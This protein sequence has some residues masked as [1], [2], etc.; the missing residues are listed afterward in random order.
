MISNLASLLKKLHPATRWLVVRLENS[1]KVPF[2]HLGR[3]RLSVAQG[4]SEEQRTGIKS[5]RERATPCLWDE[6]WSVWP[7]I[8]LES[9][10][11]ASKSYQISSQIKFLHKKEICLKISQTFIKC[12]GIFCK[13]IFL[14]RMFKNCP[15][16]SHWWWYTMTFWR[17]MWND[18]SVLSDLK[19]FCTLTSVLRGSGCGQVVSERK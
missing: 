12:L 2:S 9:S 15:I 13:T 5:V 6:R 1:Q 4:G 3:Q 14:P 19:D 10:Q 18:I 11:I 16:L 17:A 7:D 8:E